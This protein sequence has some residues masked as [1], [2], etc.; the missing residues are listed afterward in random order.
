MKNLQQNENGA[1]Y[2]VDV[3]T[4]DAAYNEA[5]RKA[6]D[7]FL[8]QVEGRKAKL[9][10]RL[11]EAEL[12]LKETEEKIKINEAK[13]VEV[14]ADLERIKAIK[15]AAAHVDSSKLQAV[16]KDSKEVYK[17]VAVPLG[18]E[19]TENAQF[20][21]V[22]DSQNMISLVPAAEFEQKFDLI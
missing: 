5:V 3:S 14:G 1:G 17:V 7:E 19:G 12:K 11:K 8:G 10:E 9:E 13:S 22:Q 20:Y 4:D 21:V 16:S 2:Y 15:D 18:S 6:A